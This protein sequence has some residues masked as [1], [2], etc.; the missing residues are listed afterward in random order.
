MGY[1]I[2]YIYHHGFNITMYIQV[3]TL[4][5]V[6]NHSDYIHEFQISHTCAQTLI[7]NEFGFQL[8]L[9]PSA[10][11]NLGIHFSHTLSSIEVYT[12]RIHHHCSHSSTA[13][14][15]CTEWRLG[16][17]QH[18]Y[19]SSTGRLLNAHTAYTDKE[20]MGDLTQASVKPFTVL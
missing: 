3:G 18:G 6:V 5:N 10:M 16:A 15:L 8:L 7:S 2:P 1:Q 13:L 14:T 12:H 9:Q 4:H 19:I 20:C 17:C 11:A